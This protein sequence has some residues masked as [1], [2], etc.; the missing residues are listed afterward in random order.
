MTSPYH[1][2]Y[3]KM[4]LTGHLILLFNLLIITFSTAG[5]KVKYDPTP[6]PKAIVVL[7]D[8][9]FTLLTPRLIRME[10]GGQ[11]DGATLAFINRNLQE[12]YFTVTEDADWTVIS[13][14]SFKITV[15][16]ILY[17]IELTSL[18]HWADQAN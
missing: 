5:G 4:S 1:L 2:Q 14:Q 9:R 16:A 6:N 8:A 3:C 11:R 18:G 10:W 17:G 12:P 15:Y 13:L 7:P